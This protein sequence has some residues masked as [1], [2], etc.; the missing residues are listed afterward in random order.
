MTR[1]QSLVN[2][3]YPQPG[4]SHEDV[5][6]WIDTL[7]VPVGEKNRHP[8]GDKTRD[9]RKEA[10]SQMADVYHLAD[11]VLVLDSFILTLPRS[12]DVVDKYLRIHLSTWHH[13]L[14]TMQEG[15]LAQRLYFQFSD[16]AESL[17]DINSIELQ[18]LDRR[19]PQT[20]C[21]PVRQLCAVELQAFYRD[22]ELGVGARHDIVT[23][24][25]SCARYLRSR[26][27]SRAE[28]ESVCVANILGLDASRV[29]HQKGPDARMACFYDLVA[30]FDTRIIFHN[31][32]RLQRDGY[33]WAPRSFLHQLPDIIDNLRDGGL[34]AEPVKHVTIIP[35][36][37][38]L[39]VQFGGF[40]FNSNSLLQPGSKTWIKPI[41]EGWSWTPKRRGDSSGRLWFECTFKMEIQGMVEDAPPSR[42]GQRWAVILPG[43]LHTEYLPVWGVMGVIDADVAQRKRTSWLSCGK[44]RD[45]VPDYSVPY[46][47][48][49]QPVC[50]V[51]V[52]MPAQETVPSDVS[53]IP[54]LAYGAQQE[55]C[56]R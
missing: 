12:A 10:I 15:Q 51:R 32:P 4:T 24:M 53:A 34:S 29:L 39:P 33:R 54:V 6:F 23:R 49:V 20:L 31:H 40:E 27:T 43:Y 46:R 47:I 35:D 44:N 17:N 14:W 19:A 22:V 50:R 11:R 38:G 5:P 37:G 25:R 30:K 9:L 48:P 36:G 52:S 42:A 28:D 7:C 56:L 2:D 55:W 18:T 1:I 21:S 16:G 3:L 8:G 41:T 45:S 26:E 13:R